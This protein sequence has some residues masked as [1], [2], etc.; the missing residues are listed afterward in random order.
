[1]HRYIGDLDRFIDMKGR[2]RKRLLGD[3][4]WKRSIKVLTDHFPFNVLIKLIFHEVSRNTQSSIFVGQWNN[5]Y[6]HVLKNVLASFALFFYWINKS[7]IKFKLFSI[8]KIFLL[9]SLF[10]FYILIPRNRLIA[11]NLF[12]NFRDVCTRSL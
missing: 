7:K 12:Q 10:F 3:S 9:L 2:W 4:Q 6:R 8:I 11:C 5:F 1:M